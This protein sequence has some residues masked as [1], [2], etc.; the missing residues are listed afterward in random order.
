[1][2]G[3]F[4]KIFGRKARR[5]SSNASKSRLNGNI[6]RIRHK[7]GIIEIRKGA[8]M[9]FEE[10]NSGNC[11]PNYRK[12]RGFKSNCQACVA[13]YI[14]RLMGFNVIARSYN[15]NPAMEKLSANTSL[16][17]LTDEGGHPQPDDMPGEDYLGNLSRKMKDGD[18]YS[19]QFMKI[20]DNFGHICIAMKENSEVFLYDPQKG[21]VMRSA[22]EMD[23]YMRVA[24]KDTIKIM[25]LTH[26]S[27]DTYFCRNIF[28]EAK[29]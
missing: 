5:E 20:G 21:K 4:G 17:F 11:N 10:A 19:L 13:V 22:R 1:M 29:K 15:N 25:N 14:A 12:G 7:R 18:V 24:D 16:A 2:I 27:M 28:D 9:S 23:R 3:I 8:P 6:I 26:V